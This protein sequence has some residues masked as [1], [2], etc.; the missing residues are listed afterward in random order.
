AG[1]TA[2]VAL[3]PL[4]RGLGPDV[5]EGALDY[6]SEARV[7]GDEFSPLSPV[8]PSTPALA[9]VGVDDVLARARERAT[10][11]GIGAGD[12]VLCTR[13]WTLPDGMIDAFLAPLSAGA[14][15]VQVTHTD[16]EALTRHRDTERTTVELT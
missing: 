16:A 5:P 3:D 11:L 8:D 7:C 6:L 10:A 14:H 4:G 9:G 1:A 12:R 13:E 15:L 2:V